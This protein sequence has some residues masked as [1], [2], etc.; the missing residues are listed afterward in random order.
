MELGAELLEL[1]LF[2]AAV[3]PVDKVEV[4]LVAVPVEFMTRA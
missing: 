2:S 4:E 1:R 3:A